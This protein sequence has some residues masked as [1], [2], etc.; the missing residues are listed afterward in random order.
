MHIWTRRQALRLPALAALGA[1]LGAL[2]LDRFPLGV[3]TDEIDED[4]LK[5]LEFLRS[6]K[7]KL[8]EIRNLWGKYN[9]SQPVEKIRE[10]RAL[11]DQHGIRLSVLGTAFFKVPLPPDTPEGR[12]ALDKEW[13]VLEAA[14]ERAEILG[15]RK[16]RTFAFTYKGQAD[17]KDLPRVWELLRESA[18]RAARRNMRL[19]VENVAASFVSTGAEAARMLAAVKED[20]LGLTWDPNNAGASG[21]RA[22]PDGYKL[23]DAARIF[24]VHL[25][26]YKHVA[27]KVEWCA[28]GDGE[29]DN[30][31][32]IRALLKAG[33]KEAFSLETHWRSPQGKEYASRTSLTGLLKVVEKV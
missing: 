7:L 1:R 9:T 2:P 13:A 21:E 17:E 15:T 11:L 19:A 30:L 20:S 31:G 24:H 3:T 8:A 14:F 33:Y 23:L 29:F 5:A 16:L 26:D 32:Q 12:K 28:V 4:L 18:R 10:A 25:R 27:G 6:F 22:F